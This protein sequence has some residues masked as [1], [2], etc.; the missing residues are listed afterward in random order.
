MVGRWVA[1]MPRLSVHGSY[2]QPRAQVAAVM[3]VMV[4]VV[5][6]VVVVGGGVAEAVQLRLCLSTAAQLAIDYCRC[7][8]AAAAVPEAGTG[9]WGCIPEAA[10]WQ[11]SSLPG[12]AA[13]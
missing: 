10:V 3:V 8:L 9:H 11:L 12:D 1:V 6:V 4:V 7:L 2:G 13:A 5:V